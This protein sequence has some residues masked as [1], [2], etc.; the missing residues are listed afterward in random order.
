MYQHQCYYSATARNIITYPD[1]LGNPLLTFYGT[2]LAELKAEWPDLELME[3]GDAIKAMEDHH[4]TPVKEIDE[5]IF[6]DA[7]Y[8]LPPENWN[9]ITD[10]SYFQMCEYIICNITRYYVSY[11]GQYYCFNDRAWLKPDEIS[12]IMC[13]F[14]VG[15]HG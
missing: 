13:T 10:G 4:K 5:D 7:M 1:R 2:P 11:K 14:L 6:Y 9:R 12:A 15:S 8:V 3:T